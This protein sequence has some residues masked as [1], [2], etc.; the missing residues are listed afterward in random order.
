MSRGTSNRNERGNTKDR[1]ARRQYLL[2]AYA[3]NVPG[4]C[5]CYRCGVLLSDAEQLLA[6]ILGV[7]AITVDRIVPGVRGGR[8][9]RSNIRPACADCNSETGGALAGSAR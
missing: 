9:V 8:Y 7:E 1:A 4:C 5:R 6:Q 2:K 3:S